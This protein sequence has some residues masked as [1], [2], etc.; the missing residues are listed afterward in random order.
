[1]P[2]SRLTPTTAD[3]ERLNAFTLIRWYCALALVLFHSHVLCGTQTGGAPSLLSCL[4]PANGHIVVSVFFILSGYLTL[5]SYLRRNEGVKAFFWRRARR[6]LPPYVLAVFVSATLALLCSTL[7]FLDALFSKATLRYLLANLTFLNFLSPTIPGAFGAP[8]LQPWV[9]PSLW[10]MKMEVGFYL[11]VPLIALAVRRRGA[12][13][14]GGW[15]YAAGVVWFL[16]FSALYRSTGVELYAFLSRQLPG[17]LMYF[18]AGIAAYAL[19]P[20]LVHRKMAVLVAAL[21]AEGLCMNFYVLRPIEP[22][23]LAALIVTIGHC[24]RRL[25]HLS[26][27]LPDHTYWLFLL[28][29]PLLQTLC[30]IAGEHNA[31]LTEATTLVAATAA[32]LLIA[33]LLRPLVRLCLRRT[34]KKA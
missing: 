12:A 28:H 6:I 31:R 21:C 23:V 2:T 5:Q 20:L 16:T 10:T 24:S 22:L 26:Q 18:G 19:R 15:L 1:M 7:P 3:E 25:S 9:N 27:R 30:A 8:N 13:I 4:L 32:A 34:T 33:A 11:T 29:A 17:Q 14:V